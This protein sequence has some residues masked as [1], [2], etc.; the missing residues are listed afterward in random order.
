MAAIVFTGSLDKNSPAGFAEMVEWL[1][2]PS[3]LLEDLLVLSTQAR[4]SHLHP[5]HPLLQGNLAPIDSMGNL[6]SLAHTS[7]QTYI[8]NNKS[9][10]LGTGCQPSRVGKPKKLEFC[11]L[12]PSLLHHLDQIVKK[13]KIN[14]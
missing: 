11:L 14:G 10:S 6:H 1:R 3:T 7:P 2:V 9:K 13:Q 5:L 4:H 8:Q 12:L